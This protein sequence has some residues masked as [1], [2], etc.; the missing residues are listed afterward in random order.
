MSDA[1]FQIDVSIDPSK[2]APGINQ[3]DAGLAHLERRQRSVQAANDNLKGTFDRLGSSMGGAAGHGGKLSAIFDNIKE[4]ASG[5]APE[6]ANLTNTL[7][8]MG[9]MAAVIGGVSLAIGAIGVASIKAAAQTQQWMAQLETTTKSSQKAKDSYNALV[10]FASTTPFDLGQSIDAFVKLRQMGMAATEGRMKSFG[11]TAAATGKTLKQ[12]IEAV[13]DAGTFQFERLLEFGIKANTVGNKVK[14]TFAGVTTTVDKNSQA[15][16]K[17]LENIG[18]TN[19]AA[20]M[21]K[22][23]DTLNGAFSN[24]GD[25][26]Q[27]MLSGI[28][29]GELGNAVKEIAKSL[30]NGITAISPFMAS[31]GNFFGSIISGVGSILNGLG[32]VWSSINTGGKG[33]Q[34]I[35]D[36]LTSGINLLADG[37]KIIGNT[38]GSVFGGIGSAIN[39]ASGSVMNYLGL[40]SKAAK[41]SVGWA[42]LIRASWQVLGGQVNAIKSQVANAF[43]SLWTGAK[44]TLG[45]IGSFLASSF[46]TPLNGIK[47]MFNSVAG[48]FKQTFGDLTFSPEGI[49]TGAARAVDL[50]IGTFRGGINVIGVLFNELPGTIWASLSP[51]F[52]TILASGWAL[53]KGI[54]S[55]VGQ[56]YT[57]V[58]GFGASLGKSI[59]SVFNSVSSYIEGVAN[60]AINMINKVITAANKLGAGMSTVANVQ[61][62][63]VPVPK[64]NTAAESAWSTLGNH[65]GSAFNRG[66]GHEAET[67]INKVIRVARGMR[68]KPVADN[69][70]DAGSDATPENPAGKNKKDKGAAE[71]ERRAKREKEFWDA[72]NGEVETAKRLPLAAEDYRKQ[73]E[74]QKILGHELGAQ[75]IARIGSLMQ[76][77]RTAKFVTTALDDH[78]KRGAELANQEQQLRAKLLGA[79]DEQLALEN[80]IADFRLNAQRQGVDLQ[81]EGYKAA[82]AQLRLDEQRA[83]VLDRQNASLAR[84][85]DV[86]RQYSG[87]YARSQEMVGLGK[88]R[89]DLD[90][91]WNGGNNGGK[92]TQEQYKEATEGLRKAGVEVANRWKDEFGARI[93]QIGE[94]FGGVMGQAI[95]KFG[96][97]IQAL[98]AAAQGD[99]T[100]AGPLGSIIGLLGKTAGGKDTAFGI[101]ANASAGKMLDSLF[102]S[103]TWAKPFKSMS[104]GFSDLKSVF[105]GTN[106]GFMQALGKVAGT[107]AAGAQIGSLTNSVLGAVG[108]K[109]NGTGSQIGGALGSAFGPIGSILGSI[110]GGILGNLFTSAPRGKAIITSGKDAQIS[111]NKGSV[112]D[113]L[114]GTSGSI[115]SGLQNIASQ[116]GGDLGNFMVSIGKYKDSYRVSSTGSSNVDGKKTSRISGLLYDGKDEAQ[117]ISIAIKDAI[118]DGAITGL[119]DLMNKALKAYAGNVDKAVNTA[120]QMKNF[121]DDYKALTDPIRAAVDSIINPL[122]A[123]RKSMVEVGATTA[124]LTKLDEYRAKKL[125]AVLK[126]QVSG[127][128]SLLDSLNGDGGGVTALTQLTQNLAKLDSFKADLAAGKTIDQDAFTSLADKIMN[129]AGSVYGT[130]TTDFQDI[131][132][133]LKGL[134]TGAITNATSAFNAAAG[135]DTT[136]KAITD[137]TNAVTASIGI[138][139]DYLRVIANAV[140]SGALTQNQGA[141]LSAKAEVQDG[142]VQQA[143]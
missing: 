8:K 123:L 113:A 16:V 55:M 59:A 15:I 70:L 80:K 34:P 9:P 50:L 91:L 129:G 86:A 84:G 11:N 1:L 44:G 101:G 74:L 128:Q 17:Y 81:S 76:Q 120:L 29:N 42:D 14:F 94:Q 52:Q 26:L 57:A 127:F 115:Q 43:T 121:E 142:R 60:S 49:A 20:A 28:G 27:Q 56:V 4:R 82:E 143:F 109:L 2:A 98:N 45:Q 112:R 90:T 19:Y 5:A 130:N 83:Q 135:A 41:D 24:V 110:G 62:A 134:T 85:L 104:D 124:D 35:L 78:A 131:I 10:K 53:L 106:G 6:V 125:D 132:G 114:A 63:K 89:Q 66:F 71:A 67:G 36:T 47:S 21:D 92:L 48:W 18:N 39:S 100:K 87:S 46:A 69:G 37:I 99:W 72:L 7:G 140:S 73:L 103:D 116:L 137:Q 12:M 79:T 96:K 136:T 68:G 95:S 38:V 32:S 97:I 88:A 105:T 13:A 40:N 22:Q 117:A 61:V 75:D 107:A 119:S 30:A 108:I 25:N 23:M 118:L 33:V 64:T 77:A 102:K 3:L 31:L 51:G 65:L 111:G 126:D 133:T 139:N 54:G 138:T 93:D 141:A 58:T 122:T